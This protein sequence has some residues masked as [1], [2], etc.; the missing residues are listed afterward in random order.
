MIHTG[1]KILPLLGVYQMIKQTR[2][3]VLNCRHIHNSTS[4]PTLT[5]F[6]FVSFAAVT[7]CFCCLLSNGVARIFF[8]GGATRTFSVISPG[9][10]PHSVGGGGSSRNFPSSQLPDQ[11]Q[12]GGGSSRQ[13]SRCKSITFPR[14]RNIF[15]TFSG[16]LRITR[17]L[18]TLTE[19][20]THFPAL[21]TPSNHVTTSIHSRKKHLTKVW[22]GAW[23]PWP[24]PG[25]ATASESS[26]CG[27]RYYVL[28]QHYFN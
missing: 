22:G 4:R 26:R 15:G 19:I 16:H 8:G 1:H 10:R 14:F 2:I 3:Y 13:F 5:R 17:R 9:G 27:E 12:W 7:F 25:Y 6:D 21:L 24:P 11:I 20:Q 23:P 18:W 28:Q